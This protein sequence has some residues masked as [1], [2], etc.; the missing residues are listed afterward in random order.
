MS[1]TLLEAL[2]TRCSPRRWEDAPRAGARAT[3]E[4]LLESRWRGAR[5]DGSTECPICQ[6]EMR[7][8]AG[9][10]RCGGCGTKLR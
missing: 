3:L 1:T 5:A 2:E 7:M 4:E 10:A 8:E 9:H 6:A